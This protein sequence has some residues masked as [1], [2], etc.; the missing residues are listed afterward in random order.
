MSCQI[1]WVETRSHTLLP[2]R[3]QR[4]KFLTPSPPYSKPWGCEKGCREAIVR[5]STNLAK[6]QG[7][8][9]RQEWGKTPKV[10]TNTKVWKK[11][12]GARALFNEV[13]S[14]RGGNTPTQ[15]PARKAEWQLSRVHMYRAEP[16][17]Y[18]RR[19]HW[20]PGKPDKC[21]NTGVNS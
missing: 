15:G 10:P 8:V 3:L 6:R 11:D 19:T 1:I 14:L 5:K 18:W 2:L 21:G 4:R 16:I 7:A 17:E 13:T 20:Y 12:G 9:A